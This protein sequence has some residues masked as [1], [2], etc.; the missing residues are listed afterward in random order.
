MT[1]QYVHLDPPTQPRIIPEDGPEANSEVFLASWWPYWL[2]LHLKVS[3]VFLHAA[4]VFEF[5]SSSVDH[6]YNTA[7]VCATWKGA[8]TNCVGRWLA[9][10]VNMRRSRLN[11]G[12]VMHFI[13][14]KDIFSAM[15]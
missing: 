8:V 15:G 5:I 11:Y 10:G 9:S 13:H 3:L 12:T 7:S 14:P 6:G 1:N 2:E 4:R